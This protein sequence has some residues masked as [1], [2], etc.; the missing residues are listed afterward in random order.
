ML[1]KTVATHREPVPEQLNREGA[2]AVQDKQR[3]DEDSEA[4]S[5]LVYALNHPLRRR[6]LRYLLSQCD[7]DEALSP[8]QASIALNYKLSNIA[9]H[10]RVL[11]DTGTL[12]LVG[13]G[14]VRGAVEHF[15]R[16]SVAFSRSAWVRRALGADGSEPADD[17]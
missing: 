2:M 5:A 10:F 4:S 3:E 9:Y 6:I 7:D 17:D 13:K 14:R 8:N 1:R 15:Y 11:A 16:P 12:T